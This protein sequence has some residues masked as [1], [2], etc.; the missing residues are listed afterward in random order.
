MKLKWKI[1]T[2]ISLILVLFSI[3]L[4]TIMYSKVSN[5][6]EI[7]TQKEL[8]TSSAM[9]L[10]TLDEKYPGDWK[11]EG[12]KLYKGAT[13]IND[14]FVAVDTIK[15][16][17]GMYASIFLNDTRITTNVVNENG[18]R[19]IG[20]KADEQVIN[21]VLKK[22]IEYTQNINIEGMDINANYTPLKDKNGDIIGMWFVG[23]SHEEVGKEVTQLAITI[24]LTSIFIII[25]G[26]FIA[27]M[28]SKHITKDLETLQK[29]ID[30][31]KSGDLS[32]KMNESILNRKDEVG[33]I[34][35][36]VEQMQNGIK[37]IVKNV[38]KSQKVTQDTYDKTQENIKISIDKSKSIEQIKLLSD[39]IFDISSQIN[40]LALNVDIEAAR[41][42]EEGKGLSV[43]A[44]EVRILAENSQLA[45]SEIQKLT[46]LVTESVEGLAKDSKNML[47]LMDNSIDK[48]YESFVQTGEQYSNDD[49]FINELVSDFAN[50]ANELEIS[51][52]SMVCK[53]EEISNNTHD[54]A[55]GSNHITQ[56]VMSIVENV[57]E[58][59]NNTK[60]YSEDLE[61][62]M[63]KFN[64]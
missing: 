14:D 6:L 59:A 4:G 52:N 56:S 25:I 42:G 37:G 32:I 24:I 2:V 53:I 16:K 12:G 48:D 27:T 45:A 11:V 54:G 5:I 50:T 57:L 64:I 55:D 63:N 26:A 34:C 44:K 60:K 21:D 41:V 19:T 31:F 38:M 28:M 58:Q 35:K 43:L 49:I 17:T 47:E 7:K 36:S 62:E 40:Q 10:I 1:C 51:I 13:P 15:E 23:I 61:N 29:N 30:V 22:G 9:G 20:T 33:K 18:E 46:Q 8:N 39:T 3:I